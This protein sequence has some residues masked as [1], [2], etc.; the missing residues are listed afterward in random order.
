[1][2]P[3][4]VANVEHLTMR[5]AREIVR[6]ANTLHAKLVEARLEKLSADLQSIHELLSTKHQHGR[7][8]KE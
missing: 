4:E 5:Q 3:G 7:E 6:L 2:R 1:M 8:T